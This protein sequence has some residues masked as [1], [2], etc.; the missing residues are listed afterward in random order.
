MQ[1]GDVGGLRGDVLARAGRQAEQR[2]QAGGGGVTLRNRDGDVIDALDL[3]H[4][5][6]EASCGVGWRK[7]PHH[8]SGR[9]KMESGLRER[10]R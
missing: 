9:R 7:G 8:I 4:L 10:C 6:G 2:A 1:K 3:D 5:F